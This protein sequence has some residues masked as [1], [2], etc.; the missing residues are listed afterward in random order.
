MNQVSTF[1]FVVNGISGTLQFQRAQ[2]ALALHFDLAP[3]GSCIEG[4]VVGR[5]GRFH[6]S[7]SYRLRLIVIC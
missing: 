4:E 2:A 3:D 5:T 7:S 6:L 1:K